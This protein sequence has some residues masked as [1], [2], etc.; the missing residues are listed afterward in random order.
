MNSTLA[1]FEKNQNKAITY[2]GGKTTIFISF[3]QQQKTTTKK[4]AISANG[5]TRP[6]KSL[7]KYRM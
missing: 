1:C 6:I 5:G 7:R 3:I 4:S 2:I